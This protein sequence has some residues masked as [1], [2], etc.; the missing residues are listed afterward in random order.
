[1]QCDAGCHLLA[2]RKLSSSVIASGVHH[3]AM[4]TAQLQEIEVADEIIDGYFE[5]SAS[6]VWSPALRRVIF[7][8]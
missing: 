3:F 5:D 6:T 7:F 2:S 1:M 4:A 8:W